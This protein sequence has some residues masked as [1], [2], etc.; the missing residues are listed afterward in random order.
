MRETTSNKFSRYH[1]I[2]LWVKGKKEREQGNGK[3]VLHLTFRVYSSGER[4]E[5]GLGVLGLGG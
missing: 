5:K 4:E 3:E 2:Q 1:G